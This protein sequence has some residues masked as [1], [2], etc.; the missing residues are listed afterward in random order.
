VQSVIEEASSPDALAEPYVTPPAGDAP[1]A[2]PPAELA[3][4]LI[5]HYGYASPLVRR[6]VG[7]GLI[8]DDDPSLVEVA[9]PGD[10]PKP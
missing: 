6:S 3:N 2:I 8:S 7:A 9:P 4:F 10:A 5:A 1:A